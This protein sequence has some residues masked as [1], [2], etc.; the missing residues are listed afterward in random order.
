MPAS[1]KSTWAKE[2][3]QKGSVGS[4]KRVNKDSLRAM[5]D[6]SK[7]SKGNER[8]VESVR[9]SIIESAL[10]QG[11]HVIVDDTNFVDRH[12]DRFKM[13]KTNVTK[14][15]GKQIQFII[16]DFNVDVDECIRRDIKRAN[17][18]G[19]TVIRQMYNKYV[20]PPVSTELQVPND[21][22]PNCIIV[23]I[24][25]TLAH[26]DGHRGWYEWH[27]VG[28]DKPNLGVIKNVMA[29]HNEFPNS[30]II[31]MS[32]RDSV[33]RSQTQKWLKKHNIPYDY[34]YMRPKGDQRADTIVKLE[35][36]KDYIDGNLNV[37]YVLDDR[38]SVVEM[39]REIGLWCFQ[40]QPGDF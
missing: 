18:V 23:D 4:T 15:T 25:G 6:V 21:N 7:W 11:I 13:I 34:L 20:S 26:N 40:V 39:W 31:I 19:E 5:L 27:G 8:F 38:N 22:L 32:G 24:D 10:M 17:G 30:E 12:M 33:C 14:A 37:D 1:G 9:D 35:M 16:K 29:Y 3:V 36:Y 28:G 2:Q